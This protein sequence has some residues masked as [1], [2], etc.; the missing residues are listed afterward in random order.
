MRPAIQ[1]GGGRWLDGREVSRES[2]CDGDECQPRGARS[3]SSASSGARNAPRANGP[4]SGWRGG[5]VSGTGGRG[6]PPGK[7]SVRRFCCRPASSRDGLLRPSPRRSARRGRQRSSRQTN[8]EVATTASELRASAA[9][10]AAVESRRGGDG[11]RR[12]R[13]AGCRE[14]GSDLSRGGPAR[15]LARVWPVRPALAGAGRSYAG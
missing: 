1:R 7:P 5:P 3:R 2:L 9:V 8:L 14:R 10:P 12:R 15:A 13:A 11:E 6:A 4:G